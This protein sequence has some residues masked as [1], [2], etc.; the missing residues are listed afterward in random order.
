MDELVLIGPL[1]LHKITRNKAYVRT[2]YTTQKA[3]PL[4]S[5]C[6]TASF[7]RSI[8]SIQKNAAKV[9]YPYQLILG[10]KDVI[11]DNAASRTWHDKT[12][13]AKKELKL[14]AGAF[15]E[16]SKEP[17][18]GIFVETILKFCHS[19]APKNFGVLDPKTV[20]FSKL[21][22]PAGAAG[23]PNKRRRLLVI[24]YFVIGFILALVKQSKKLFLI[25]PAMPFLKHW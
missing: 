7:I 23:A 19:S 4:M 12:T 25:W 16:L 24:L 13:S 6:L 22:Q 18:N 1:A 17:N 20:N 14:M 8:D 5:A 11:V 15:H 21:L 2:F 3:T 10:E 9:N